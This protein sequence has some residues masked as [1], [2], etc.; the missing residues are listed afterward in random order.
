MTTAMT[1]E[2]LDSGVDNPKLARGEFAT[3]VDAFNG[4]RSLLQGG[5]SGK[6]M[7]GQGIGVDP[8]FAVN[9]SG[10]IQT[11]LRSGAAG[12]VLA[13]QGVGVDPAFVAAGGGVS[14]FV[15]AVSN[16][17]VSATGDGTEYEITN[18]W[19]EM[20][21]DEGLLNNGVFTVPESGQYLISFNVTVIG[22]TAGYGNIYLRKNGSSQFDYLQDSFFL[23]SAPTVHYIHW[24]TSKLYKLV[25][26]DSLG[27]SVKVFG[28]TK[29]YHI[30]GPNTSLTICRMGD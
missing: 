11:L 13:G 29:N 3:N 16:T 20:S 19:I 10:G 27:F 22:D 4:I 21:D 30:Y 23:P 18:I 5:E 24:I 9:P 8:V 26:G 17:L 28:T 6:I 14:H 7:T 25:V 2:H 12:T 15:N 1:K